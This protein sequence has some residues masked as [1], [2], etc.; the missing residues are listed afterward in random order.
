MASRLSI[1]PSS[2]AKHG[3]KINQ[4]G[5]R[6]TALELM[7]YPGIGIGQL[8][9]VWPE[10]GRLSAEVRAQLEIEAAYA[11]Y[12]ER[13][14]ADVEA[15]RRDEGLALPAETD[16]RALPGLSR[17]IAQKLSETRPMTLGQAGRIEGMTPAAL[18]IL[19]RVANAPAAAR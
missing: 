19:L 12:L 13:Q 6:R 11:G 10:L 8:A 9:V 17:E 7:S 2:A 14:Q 15:F 1:T 16:Y 3:L 5:V 4:D 18:M